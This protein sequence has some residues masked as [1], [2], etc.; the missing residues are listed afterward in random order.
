MI[1][2]VVLRRGMQDR[3]ASMLVLSAPVKHRGEPECGILSPK[4]A[5]DGYRFEQ[6]EL[7]K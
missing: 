3:Q 6:V 4:T 7:T 1:Y 2:W 5:Y